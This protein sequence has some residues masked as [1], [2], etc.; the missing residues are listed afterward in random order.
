[1]QRLGIANG[2]PQVRYVTSHLCSLPILS[3]A[4]DLL[5]ITDYLL[6]LEETHIYNVG[7]VL[8]LEQRKVKNL[9]RSDSFL[10]DV[11]SAWLR[12]EDQVTKKGNPSWAVLISALNHA[13]VKQIGIADK[14]AKDMHYRKC[15]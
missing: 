1:M 5:E 2:P 14:I 12:K 7:L 11:I 8:G 4:V 6:Q 13:R 10:D 9:K 3:A 15:S